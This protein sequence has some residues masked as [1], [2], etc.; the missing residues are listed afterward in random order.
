MD[1]RPLREALVA[2]GARLGD[3]GLIAAGEGNLSI[4]LPGDRILI[5]P[6][7]QRKDALEPDDLVVV[8]L[9]PPTEKVDPAPGR[10]KP[11]SDLAIHRAI[12]RAR[13]D[14][15]AV[16][17]AHVPAAMALTLA[18]EAPDPAALPET[19]LLLP[20][21]PTVPFGAP[22]SPELASRIAATLVE[23]DPRPNAVLLEVHG[24][25]AVGPDIGAAL[26]R[27]ELVDV[28][29]RVWLDATLLRA[30]KSARGGDA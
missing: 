30:A 24:A 8:P 6:A 26:D 14:V 5:T 13:E 20:Y 7:G 9:D 22:G 2:G 17:H 15:A 12:Y 16:V 27:M 29:C 23:N 21:L 1:D 10:L 3:R 28:L 11:S 25:I 18:G 4:R 19:A